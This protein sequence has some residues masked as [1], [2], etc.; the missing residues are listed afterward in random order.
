MLEEKTFEF[1]KT[2]EE[3]ALE[4]ERSWE[5]SGGKDRGEDE[6]FEE[7]YDVKKTCEERRDCEKLMKE[8]E[9]SCDYERTD[10]ETDFLRE[11]KKKYDALLIE[12]AKMEADH[13]ETLDKLTKERT[14]AIS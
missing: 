5:D 3:Q 2:V 11:E 10:E 1:E 9:R 12:K 13:S 6:K 14:A 4:F 7:L 8:C